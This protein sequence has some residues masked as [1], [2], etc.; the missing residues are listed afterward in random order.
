M[1]GVFVMEN[2]SIVYTW[3][4]VSFQAVPVYLIEYSTS[5]ICEQDRLSRRVRIGEGKQEKY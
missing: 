3:Y 5:K 4:L 2:K 1:L